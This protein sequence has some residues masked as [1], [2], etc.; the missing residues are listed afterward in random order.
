MH[1]LQ[2]SEAMKPKKKKM[3][4]LVRDIVPVGFAI[5]SV[6]HASLAC[7]L[8][9]KDDPDYIDWL[10]NSFSKV[11]CKVNDDQFAL[12]FHVERNVPITES[13]LKGELVA[14]AFCPRDVYPPMFKTF[15]FYH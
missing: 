14:L 4:I 13:A 6:A 12:A 10:D 3:Y 15:N 8:K 9:F 5:N 2:S 7:H 11:T 1:V